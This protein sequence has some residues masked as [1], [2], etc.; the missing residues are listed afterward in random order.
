MSAPDGPEHP[1]G[2]KKREYTSAEIANIVSIL[3]TDDDTKNGCKYDF[4][5][6]KLI[7]RERIR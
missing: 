4:T 3:H 1:A 5:N 6:I 2:K 7:T